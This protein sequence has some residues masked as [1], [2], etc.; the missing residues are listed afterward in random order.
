MAKIK[1][2]DIKEQVEKEGWKLLSETYKNLDEEMIFQCPE[3]HKVYS[4]WKKLRNKLECPFCRQ[5][6]Y[7]DL[8]TKVVSKKKGSTRILALDQA[9]KISG[10]SIFDNGE[11]IK[12]GVFETTLD[13]EIERDCAIRNWLINMIVNWQPDHIALEGIQLQDSSSGVKI[14]VTTYETLARLQGILM[15]TCFE[16]KIPYVICP[17]NTWRSHTGV[18]GRARTDRKRSAQLIIKKSYD[19]SVTEDEADAVLI[20]KYAAGTIGYK[21]EIVVWE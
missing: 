14:G 7:K 4:S 16:M 20:G 12:Y 18:K 15:A 17:T 13:D 3:N 10:Y 9:T 5:N 11:L 2:E 21:K 19:V 8:D 6:K 1:F